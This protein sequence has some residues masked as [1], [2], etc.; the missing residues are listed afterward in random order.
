[1]MDAMFGRQHRAAGDRSCRWPAGVF[2]VGA[3]VLAACGDSDD[4]AATAAPV[5]TEATAA[6]TSVGANAVPAATTSPPPTTTRARPTTTRA[7]ATTTAAPS[8]TLPP[9]TASIVATLPE[10][11]TTLVA[12]PLGQPVPPPADA[13]AAEPIIEVGSIAIPK[14]GVDMTM[15]EGVRLSTLE[16]G[17]G[18]WPGTA[19]P[20][21]QGNV[22]VGGHRTSSHRVFR[23]VD[24]LASGDEIIFRDDGQEYVYRVDRVEI[25]EPTAVWIVD[26]TETATATLF[27]C[28][29]PGS[30]AQR[31]VVFADLATT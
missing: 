26:P 10:T 20:G 27:A 15:Y 6:P 23:D 7:A 29:P 31:I 30:T 5:I 19:M 3:L 18:H 11:S 28:H 25:V 12:E 14:L 16:Y 8:T 24:Q 2:A 1:M 17:P 22:V 9:T 21:Q 4:D 13:N